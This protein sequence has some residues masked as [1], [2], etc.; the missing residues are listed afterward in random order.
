MPDLREVFEVTTKQMGEPDLDS[1]RQQEHRQRKATRNRRMGAIAVVAA[2]VVAGVV[3]GIR[4]LERDDVQPA[5]SGANSTLLEGAE[6]QTLSIVDVGSGTAAAFTAPAGASDFDFTLDGSMV[7]YTDLDEDGNA[8]V[9]VM[10][11]DGSNARQ[12]TRGEGDVRVDGMPG[13]GGPTGDL[14]WSPDGSMIAYNRD[15]S[16]G[17]QI[18]T[19]RVSTGCRPGSRT[20][21]KARWVPA[22]GRRTV[23]PSSSRPRT[24]LSI[25]TRPYP[26]TSERNRP[27]RSCRTEA[28]PSY[29]PTALGSPSTPG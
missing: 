11:A 27:R 23:A 6:Q 18:L 12:L 2:L 13:I 14:D 4:A 10:D 16:D 29:R 28:R 22:A 26:S 15:T 9:F 7:A 19:V 25:I 5:G 17:P 1:W 20:N 24:P 21:R 3:L 8:Q